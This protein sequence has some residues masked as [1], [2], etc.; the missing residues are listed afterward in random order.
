[1]DFSNG[2]SMKASICAELTAGTAV[3]MPSLVSVPSI[4]SADP[5][6]LVIVSMSSVLTVVTASSSD[7]EGSFLLP[8]LLTHSVIAITQSSLIISLVIG[9]RPRVHW[10]VF[11]EHVVIM[12]SS[13]R[14]VNATVTQGISG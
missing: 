1:M 9:S 5:V 8:Q 14:I 3:A 10:S 4:T 12:V 7:E 11:V 6:V 13:H 2:L